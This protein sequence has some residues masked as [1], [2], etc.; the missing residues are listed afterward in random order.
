MCKRNVIYV[1]LPLDDMIITENYTYKLH[2]KA[3]IR[4]VFDVNGE[5]KIIVRRT[6]L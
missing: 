2:D 1:Y 5:K 4:I 3:N 6:R